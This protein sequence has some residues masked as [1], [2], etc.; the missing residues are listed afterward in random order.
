[1][2]IL[3][4]LLEGVVEAKKAGVTLSSIETQTRD[5]AANAPTAL[6]VPVRPQ[7]FQYRHTGM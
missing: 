5:S 4:N 6:Q 3:C 1:M 7:P 2:P